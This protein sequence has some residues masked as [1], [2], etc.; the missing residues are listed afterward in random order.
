MDD[1]NEQDKDFLF[2]AILHKFGELLRHDDIFS[3]IYY[4]FRYKRGSKKSPYNFIFSKYFAV[5]ADTFVVIN[6]GL[7]HLMQ[8]LHFQATNDS[9]YLTIKGIPSIMLKSQDAILIS[10]KKAADERKPRLIR[11]DELERIVWLSRFCEGSIELQQGIHS[12]A[13]KI[14]K[15]SAAAGVVYLASIVVI[16]SY[17]YHPKYLQIIE[18]EKQEIAEAIKNEKEKERIE[19]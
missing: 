9:S 8:F 5:V 7:N 4:Y 10:A 17:E 16:E 15:W 13:K 1:S 6:F 14:F 2:G 12:R 19:K 11:T 3:T 18:N